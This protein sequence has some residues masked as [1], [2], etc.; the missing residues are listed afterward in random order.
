ME[1]KLVFEKNDKFN[2]IKISCPEGHYITNWNEGDEITEFSYG[3]EYYCPADTDLT[4]YRC[5]TLEE[6]DRLQ[7]MREDAEREEM[8]KEKNNVSEE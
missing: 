2:F 1:H 3:L 5:I 7:K 4:K 8:E 6:G